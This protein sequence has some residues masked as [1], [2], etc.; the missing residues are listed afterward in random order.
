MEDGGDDMQSSQRDSIFKIFLILVVVSGG[1]QS[2][3]I[4]SQQPKHHSR[5]R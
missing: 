3:E 5:L 4:T 2:Q 1:M